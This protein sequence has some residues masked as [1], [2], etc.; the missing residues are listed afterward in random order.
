MLV[1]R[2]FRFEAAHHLPD[3]PG[4]CQRPHGHSYRLNVACAA[5]VDPQTGMA[6]DFGDLK[7]VVNEQVLDALDHRDLN[8]I[9]PIPTAE[10]IAAW[11]WERLKA[12]GLPLHEVTLFE[13]SNCWVV[14]R[15]EGLDQ[16][17]R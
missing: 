16:A 11:I 14:Y 15:G 13:T 8:E 17:A 12:A 10:R 3:H 2:E 7:R 4:K 5:P 9:L 6:I 1:I